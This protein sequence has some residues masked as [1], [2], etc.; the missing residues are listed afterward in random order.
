M[1][2]KINNEQINDIYLECNCLNIIIGKYE[3]EFKKFFNE[4]NQNLKVF[5]IYNLIAQL[6]EEIQ[7][8]YEM[9]INPGF[10]SFEKIFIKE[11]IENSIKL[12]CLFHIDNLILL[13]ENKIFSDPE[14]ESDPLFGIGILIYYFVMK[15]KYPYNSTNSKEILQKINNCENLMLRKKINFII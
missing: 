14:N 5:E 2:K 4:K 1:V 3:G 7:K 11:K 15:D 13:P 6:N 8:L 9:K 12:K 10:I